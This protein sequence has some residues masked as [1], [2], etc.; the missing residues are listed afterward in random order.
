MKPGSRTGVLTKPTQILLLLVTS[1]NKVFIFQTLAFLT[2]LSLLKCFILKAGH[3]QVSCR[4]TRRPHRVVKIDG[5]HG[6]PWKEQCRLLQIE[7]QVVCRHSL[8]DVSL[9]HRDLCCFL[10]FEPWRQ[11]ELCYICIAVV[12]LAVWQ[13]VE[14]T[15]HMLLVSEP[16]T[17]VTSCTERRFRNRLIP[18]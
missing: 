9:T 3:T 14:K 2:S 7:L 16:Q 1:D 11:N 8:R 12:G 5:G 13:W 18:G 6:L 15:E 10:G 17:P 4:M